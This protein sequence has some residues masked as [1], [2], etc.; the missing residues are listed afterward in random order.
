MLAHQFRRPSSPG[1]RDFVD[2]L[3]ALRADTGAAQQFA[4]VPVGEQLHKPF[5]RTENHRFAVVVEGVARQGNGIDPL[6]ARLRARST[7]FGPRPDR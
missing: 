2:Q 6:V 4:G 7:R 3:A 5:L 1:R